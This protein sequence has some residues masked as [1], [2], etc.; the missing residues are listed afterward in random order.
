MG[1]ME[2][3]NTYVSIGVE[4]GYDPNGTTRVDKY[5]GQDG[6]EDSNGEKD[7]KEKNIPCYVSTPMDLQMRKFYRY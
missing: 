7:V 2:G 4:G 1:I 6:C 3:G 5:D